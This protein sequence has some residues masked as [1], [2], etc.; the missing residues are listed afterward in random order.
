MTA[1]VALTYQDYAALPDDGQR[2]EIHDGE[3][4]V[5][6]APTALHQ[7]VS[8]RLFRVLDAHVLARTL[9]LV[10]Y[11][12][13]DVILSDGPNATTIL[14]PDLVYLDHDRLAALHMR[15]VEGP[16]TLAIEILSP[17]TAPADRRRK[18]AL[19]A[20]YGV[21]YLWLVDPNA[22]DVEVHVL[23]AGAYVVQARVAGPQPV[24]LPPFTGLGLVPSSLW[25]EPLPLRSGGRSP[26]AP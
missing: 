19:Y 16:P 6:P 12:P 11:A 2:Y 25:P 22:R 4:S 13:L 7:I 18:R 1:R 3:L 5:T 14:Q 17:S 9:G 24:D 20:R 26:L 10:L 8:A 15:G 23:G 21:P